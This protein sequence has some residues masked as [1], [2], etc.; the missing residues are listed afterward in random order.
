MT[1][2]M[3]ILMTKG[4]Y[5]YEEL[6]IKKC[7]PGKNKHGDTLALSNASV[8]VRADKEQKRYSSSVKVKEPGIYVN[9]F[10][11]GKT[12]EIKSVAP[13]CQPRSLCIASLFPC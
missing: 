13:E 1:E 11:L 10:G 2:E 8:V 6:R 3:K 12:L 5:F 4:S 7:K 9:L